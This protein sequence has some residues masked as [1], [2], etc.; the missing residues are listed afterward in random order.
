MFKFLLI[1]FIVCYLIYKLGG[2]LLKF[3]FLSLGNKMQNPQNFGQA[4]PNQESRRSTNGNVDID[5]VPKMGAD[6][7]EKIFNGG[8]YVDYEEIK[9]D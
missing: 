9:K 7:E 5:Y 2:Y 6:K 8:E 4:R 1:T 3:F